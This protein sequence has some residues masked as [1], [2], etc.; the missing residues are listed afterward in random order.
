MGLL[1]F[2]KVT[3]GIDPG[4]NSLRIIKDGELIFNEPSQISYDTTN[5]KVS[6]IGNSIRSIEKDVIIKPVNG[7]IFDFHAFEML[8]RRA[9]KKGLKLKSDIF[10]KSYIMYCSILSSA[11]DIEKRAYRDSGEHVG[12]VEF[13]MIHQC[14]CS[15][16]GMDLLFTRKHFILIDFGSSKIEITVFVNGIPISVGGVRMG[17]AKIARLLKNFF[18]R[19]YKIIVSDKEIDFLLEELGKPTDEIKIQYTTVKIS[20]IQ[21]LLNHFFAL[22]NDELME[23]MELVSNHADIHKVIANGVYFTGGGSTINYLVNQIKLDDRIK[24]TVSQNPFMDNINGL[25]KI[26]AEKEKF[27]NYI[28]M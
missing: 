17:T 16:I 19:K 24:R 10:S 21:D 22:V 6:G 7:A 4:S 15:A 8:V 9:L 2:L 14:C 20:A 3:I 23:T 11:T 26:M 25:R 28:M 12:A 1:D 27:K 18:H 13:F 5:D